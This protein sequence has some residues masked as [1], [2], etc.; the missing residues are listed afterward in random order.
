[1]NDFVGSARSRHKSCLD[2]CLS[3][4]FCFFF[5]CFFSFLFIFFEAD[6]YR[7]RRAAQRGAQR[8]ARGRGEPRRTQGEPDENP[9]RTER[10][11]GQPKE[12]CGADP[13]QPTR[14]A[15]KGT[16][17]RGPRKR[18]TKEN[19]PRTRSIKGLGEAGWCLWPPF[20]PRSFPACLGHRGQRQP[21]F[22]PHLLQQQN[23]RRKHMGRRLARQCNNTRSRCLLKVVNEKD[24]RESAEIRWRSRNVQSCSSC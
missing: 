20:P 6:P 7:P 10:E 15:Q 2:L 22:P 16:A 8:E 12:A 11:R 21:S 19:Q 5:Y 17:R 13:L 1:M 9:R 14:R 4:F 23:E 24:V 18:R 3:F